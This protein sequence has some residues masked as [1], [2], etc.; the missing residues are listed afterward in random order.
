M[1]APPEAVWAVLAD[2]WEYPTF[3]VGA[4]SMRAVDED[5][6]AP[7]SRLHHSVGVWPLMIQDSTRV[8][9]ADPPR[10]LE[11]IA[12]GW[13]AGEAVVVLELEPEDGGTR[14]TMHEDAVAGPGRWVPPPLRQLFGRPRNAETLRRLDFLSRGR[15]GL[16]PPADRD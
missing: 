15:A 3:V 8:I 13:P 5:W 12:R 4:S 7:E 1:A 16:E 14:V 6:P 2:G 11:L 10:R 9:A